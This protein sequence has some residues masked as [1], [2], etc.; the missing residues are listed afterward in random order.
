M[1]CDFIKSKPASI[2]IGDLSSKIILQLRAITSPTGESVDFTET[3][4]T[5]ETVWARVDT[6]RGETVFD[7]TNTERDVTHRFYIRFISGITAET[8]IE[9]NDIK[10]DIL[11]V[12]NLQENDEFY[13][14]RAAK[15][16]I[17]TT[18]VNLS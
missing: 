8:W 17:K 18:N 2:C 14:L 15:R 4:T 7:G 9:W 16:G 1:S 13:L 11:D 10:F 6:V 12:E 5:A 3:F